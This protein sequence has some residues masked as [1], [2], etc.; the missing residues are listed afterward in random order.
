MTVD[1]NT[2]ACVTLICWTVV[3]WRALT[4]LIIREQN[5]RGPDVVCVHG[6]EEEEHEW[7]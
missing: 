2:V 3:A 7:E 1:W 6:S 4:I 5:K